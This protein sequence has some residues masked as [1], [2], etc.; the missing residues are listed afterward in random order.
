MPDGCDDKVDLLE[1]FEKIFPMAVEYYAPEERPTFEQIKPYIAEII[2]D[3]KVYL[4]NTD[5]DAQTEIEWDN[6][7]MH[8]LVG[9][10]M[11]NRG[12]TVEN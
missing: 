2:H 7:K 9:A 4:V 10:E 5:K 1:R 11:L 6:Y 3:K 8:I 12:F